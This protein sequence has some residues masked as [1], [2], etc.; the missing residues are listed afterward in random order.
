VLSCWPLRWW[1]I[2]DS[3]LIV[4]LEAPTAEFDAYID[5]VERVLDS[6][7]VEPAA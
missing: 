7:V 6:I 3:T 5:L 1:E 2:D 4:C